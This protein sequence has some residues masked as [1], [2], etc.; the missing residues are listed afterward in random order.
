MVNA[1]VHRHKGFVFSPCLTETALARLQNG[2]P[3]ILQFRVARPGDL[4]LVEDR[5]PLRVDENVA[6][7]ART[8]GGPNVEVKVS[9]PQGNHTGRLSMAAISSLFGFADN[10]R[11]H[12]EKFKVKIQEEPDAID[13]FEEQIREETEL[14]LPDDIDD[15]YQ[16]RRTFLQHTFRA[17]FRTI[18]RLYGNG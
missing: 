1:K 7:L 2:T 3:R 15:N 16:M 11:D 18:E 10:N 9:W 14:D 6:A 12:F 13:L 17:H 5:D 8:F 4:A